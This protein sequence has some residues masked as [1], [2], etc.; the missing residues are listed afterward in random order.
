MY[1]YFYV[2]VFL[3]LC[4]F[5]IVCFILF[6]VFFVCKC[7]LY[8]C[9]RVATQLQLTNIS[10]IVFKKQDFFLKVCCENIRVSAIYIF[11]FQ[12]LV[13]WDSALCGGNLTNTESGSDVMPSLSKVFVS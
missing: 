4:M 6:C 12:G 7:V 13:F 10:H 9:H 1:F 5:C 3:F 2:Y 11:A 8:Y